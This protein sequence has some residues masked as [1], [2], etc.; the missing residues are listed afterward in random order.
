LG[1]EAQHQDASITKDLVSNIA[2]T[3]TTQIRARSLLLLATDG[4][5]EFLEAE[6][7]SRAATKM[8]DD[9]LSAQQI[10]EEITRIAMRRSVADNATVIV[11]CME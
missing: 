5:G 4:V 9:G 8:Y 6:S 3:S 10:A 7:A 1:P 2:H 11:V